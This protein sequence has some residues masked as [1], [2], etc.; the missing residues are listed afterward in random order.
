MHERARA[1]HGVLDAGPLPGGGFRV[2]AVLPYGD[3]SAAAPVPDRERSAPPPLPD[4][5]RGVHPL[6]GGVA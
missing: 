2:H 3:A 5:A 6:P 1:L 4:R